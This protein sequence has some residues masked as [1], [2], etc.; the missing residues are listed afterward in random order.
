MKGHKNRPFPV[1]NHQ[2]SVGLPRRETVRV[3]ERGEHDLGAAVPIE[4]RNHDL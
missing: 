4:I 1:K 2:V 3:P